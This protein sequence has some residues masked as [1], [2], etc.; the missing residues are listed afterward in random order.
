MTV[1]VVSLFTLILPFFMFWSTKQ[2]FFLHI[3]FNILALVSLYLFSVTTALA[4]L[5]TIFDQTVYLTTI[6]GILLNPLFLLPGGYLGIF[7]LYS[8]LRLTW[9]ERMY[10]YSK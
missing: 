10:P 1:I 4:V 7:A 6:H 9:R 3:L 2:T 8:L 5:Q